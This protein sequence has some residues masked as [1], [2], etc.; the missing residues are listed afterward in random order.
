MTKKEYYILA[1]VFVIG[2]GLLGFASNGIKGMLSAAGASIIGFCLG[3]L[4]NE[5]E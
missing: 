4:M 5:W 3:R 1:V 2:G